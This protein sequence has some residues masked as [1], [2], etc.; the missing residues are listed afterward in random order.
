MKVLIF[1]DKAFYLIGQSVFGWRKNKRPLGQTELI[2]NL[3]LCI[4][5]IT[6]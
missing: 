1:V 5:W 4:T 3:G 2:D 6:V